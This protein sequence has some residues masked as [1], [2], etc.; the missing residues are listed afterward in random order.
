LDQYGIPK[1]LYFVPEIQKKVK[2]EVFGK[3]LNDG[4]YK[5]QFRSSV[6]NIIEPSINKKILGKYQFTY[7]HD[8]R[9]KLKEQIGERNTNGIRKKYQELIQ[10]EEKSEAELQEITTIEKDYY[11][12]RMLEVMNK[13]TGE[14]KMRD[15]HQRT[16]LPHIDP[17]TTITPTVQERLSER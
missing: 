8:E 9:I 17:K 14:G 7:T 1:S 13:I 15:I 12:P 4:K 2:R 5:L 11:I 16:H 10:K 3:P 6:G